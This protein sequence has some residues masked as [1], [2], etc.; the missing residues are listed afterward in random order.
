VSL[1]HGRWRRR[2]SLLAAEALPAAES[3]AT[4]A[5]LSSCARCQGELR[6]LRGVLEL[7]AADPVRT[8]EPPV[9]ASFL[10]TRIAARLDS[11]PAPL[12]APAPAWRRAL[13]PL[14]SA[15]AVVAAVSVLRQPSSAPPALGTPASEVAV[16][17]EAL[18]RLERAVRR[19]QTAR[20]LDDAQA[21]LVNVAASPQRCAR[22][23][24]RFDL[25]QESQRSRQLLARRALVAE[26]DREEL[27]LVRPVLRDVE[28][29]LREVADLD[30][31]AR[32]EELLAIQGELER[33]RLLMK[34]DLATREL[35]G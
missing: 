7:L 23:G 12:V 10:L 1:L 19:E 13:L 3:E 27:A 32:P 6:E 22:R 28:R 8:A 2:V 35:L 25:D 14:V 5:H 16:P 9:P 24:Q 4:L 15:A 18:D 11:A 31:C 33:R 20:Y 21:V 34:I 17:A 29:L 26:S 30:P